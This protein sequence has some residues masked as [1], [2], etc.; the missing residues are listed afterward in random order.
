MPEPLIVTIEAD[1]DGAVSINPDDGSMATRQPD[2]G[3]VVSLADHRP[4]GADEDSGWF[5]NLVDK[6]DAMELAKIANEL[7]DGIDADNTSRANYLEIRAR[8]LDLL[9]TELKEPKSGLSDSTG[10]VEGM[11]SVTNPLLLEAV[12]K[13][14][15]NSVGEFLPAQ[16][17]VKIDNDGEETAA[18]DDL[19][20]TLQRDMNHY[21]TKGM[22][23]YY[24]STSAML[25]W[26]TYFG[27]SGFKRVHRCP[28]RRRPVSDWVKSE[29]LIVSDAAT[30][31]STCG[32]ITFEDT[33]RPS[34]MKRMQ[35]IGAYRKVALTEPTPQPTSVDTKI[36]AIQGTSPTKE[37]PED[38]DYTIWESQ[39]E[40]D[41]PEFAKGTKFAG[42]GLP[43]PYL[44]TLEKDSREILAIRR[45]WNEDDEECQR[46]RMYVKY[47]YVPGPGFY[48]TGL[49]NIL[50]NASAA[51]TAA[52]REALDAGMFASF[53][54]GLIV[55]SGTR[56]NSSVFRVAP[57]QFDPVDT[58]GAKISDAIMPMPYRDVTPGLM[59]MIDRITQQ[60]QRVGGSVDIPT[61]EGIA[62][63]PVGTMMAHIEQVTK[64][65]LATHKGMHQAQAEEIELIVDLFREHPEDFWRSLPKNAKSYWNEQKLL[66]ALEDVA[67]IPVSDPN[68]P[69]HIHRIAKALGLVELSSHP[70]IGPR[71]NPDEVTR[72]VLAA[73]REDP[74]GLMQPAPQ[75]QGPPD[76][77]GQ[78]KIMDAQTKRDQLGLKAQEIQSKGELESQKLA[79][80][81]EVE[82]IRLARE[83]VIHRADMAREDRSHQ[84]E[85][86]QAG[87]EMQMQREEHQQNLGLEHAKHGLAVQAQS[88]AQ[89][90][91]GFP[92]R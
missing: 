92:T 79:G 54:G 64:I 62:N 49:L 50:G 86:A 46:R 90:M 21:F 56:Q 76:L 12:L 72:R 66:Q 63:V 70:V 60:A 82:S 53:P 74:Q 59:N 28:L 36:A 22:K 17:P 11:S 19:A 18:E 69:S 14:W 37:R 32:R 85:M 33:M 57:G 89:G 30:D 4:K 42:E 1:D 68:T 87:A 47:P 9:G 75:P 26:G 91:D 16:G 71:L 25:L 23:E 8:G 61:Q 58:G 31:F 38:Q 43:L 80:E 44:V 41:L 83:E 7:Y 52:W 67:L 15:A 10:M 77:A 13:G 48:G 27:G 81:K 65:M 55:K 34:V 3:V 20:E 24:P 6:I 73:M 78:A 39:C 2:G 5:A 45:D 40:L 88:H 51:M 84:A 29:K 35:I